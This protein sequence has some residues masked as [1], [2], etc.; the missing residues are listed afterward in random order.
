MFYNK[1]MMKEVNIKSE[2][3]KKNARCE[4]NRYER[5]ENRED[6]VRNRVNQT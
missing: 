4:S 6:F 1:I 5:K 2:E 3:M